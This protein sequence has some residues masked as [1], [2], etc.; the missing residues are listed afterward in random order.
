MSWTAANIPDQSGKVAV[1]TGANGG[2]GLETARELT[3]TG[4]HVI[5][6]ARNMEKAATAKADI[7]SE[8]PR[9]SLDVRN[10]DLASLAS[11]MAFA[12]G[13]MA[14]HDTIDLL[15]NNAG[16]MGTPEW[17]TEDG[18]EMQFGTNHLGHFYLTYLL[19]PALLRA[20]RARIVNTSSTARFFA[21]SYDLSNPHNRGTYD[22]WIA[23]G[24]S[25]RANLHFTLELNRRLA[26]AGSNVTAHAADPGFSKTDL[27]AASARNSEDGASQRFFRVT[28][29]WFGQSAARGALPQ[30]QA[31]TDPAAK[32]GTI[33]RPRWITAG[34]PVVGG[35]SNKLSDPADLKKLWEVSEA[36]T[37]VTF[38]VAA[39]VGEANA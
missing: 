34:T 5:I 33:Y 15:F 18:F 14:E 37:G 11:I 6:A 4:A 35:I 21:G 25:K 32:G 12:D 39:M 38:D 9:A 7:L 17:Q 29:G 1:I 2:L 26:E 24:Y 23:Y 8:L 28:V 16:V 10:L 30:L 20:D 36:E 27:Q 31:G 13:I 3:R 19:M 22:P